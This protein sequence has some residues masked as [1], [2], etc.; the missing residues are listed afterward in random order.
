MTS[1]SAHT[2]RRTLCRAALAAL[3]AAAVGASAARAATV[4]KTSLDNGV[5]GFPSAGVG[6]GVYEPGPP[7]VPDAVREVGRYNVTVVADPAVPAE[8]PFA[9]AWKAYAVDDI[10]H[11]TDNGVGYPMVLQLAEDAFAGEFPPDV[12]AKLTW[13]LR[14][15][16]ELIAG[17]ADATRAAAAVQI[18]VWQTLRNPPL[19]APRADLSEP[20]IDAAVNELAVKFTNRMNAGVDAPPPATPTLSLAAGPVASCAATIT[21]TGTPGAT[22]TLTVDNNG[23]LTT[24]TVTLAADGTATAGVSTAPGTTVTVTGAIATAGVLVRADIRGPATLDEHLTD[25]HTSAAPEE[26]IFLAGTAPVT[27]SAPVTCPAPPP[28]PPSA[29]PVVTAVGQPA[30]TPGTLRITKSAPPNAVAG[31]TITYTIRVR[32]TGTTS[33]NAVVL[34]DVLPQGLSFAGRPAGATIKKGAASWNL[35]TL[36]PGA[37]RTVSLRVRLDS[38]LTGVRCNTATASGDNAQTVRARA[39]STVR[40]VAGVT[41]APAVTG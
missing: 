11:H 10:T 5:G 31:T 35:G 30:V 19:L 26:L 27:A 13:L 17:E 2:L 32:N 8:A 1:H 25:S 12:A 14:H 23:V 18:V 29:P 37:Q 3:L 28:T 24:R 22:V 15:A 39:C 9:G 38:G 16:D 21:A 40:A 4:T 41:R 7:G 36:A 34:R 20:T 33:V 6:L